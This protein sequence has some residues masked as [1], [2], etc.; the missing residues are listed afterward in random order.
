MD[1]YRNDRII[2]DEGWQKVSTPQVVESIPKEESTENSKTEELTKKTK[3]K[4][5]KKLTFPALISIQLVICVMIAVTA[6][7]LKFMGSDAFSKLSDWY[8][9]MSEVTLVPNSTFE[10]FDLSKYLPASVD[11]LSSTKDEI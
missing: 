10:N 11:Q 7:A 3:D 9:K 1:D 2:Y 8:H 6:F 4:E 5:K